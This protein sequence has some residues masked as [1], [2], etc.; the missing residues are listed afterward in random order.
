MRTKN[1][2]DGQNQPNLPMYEDKEPKRCQNQ[3]NLP[4]YEEGST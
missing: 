2:K 1:L 3:P 4:M